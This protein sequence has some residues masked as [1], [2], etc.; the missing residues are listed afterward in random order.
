[1]DTEEHVVLS[2]SQKADVRRYRRLWISRQD[3]SEALAAIDLIDK[4]KLKRASRGA[5]PLDLVILTTAL[6]VSYS[7]PFVDTRG[8]K[9][10]AERTLPGSILRTLTRSQ[11]NLHNMLINMR[12]KEIAHSDAE[13]LELSFRI[14]PGGESAIW[15]TARDP[16]YRKELNSLRV[17]IGKIE[18][19]ID[20]ICN[21]LGIRLPNQTWL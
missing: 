10:L 21:D 15:R 16:L 12:Q 13:S 2:P 3:L 14:F 18:R 19:E 8:S 5:H 9:D 11:R 6:V 1:M 17:V 20:R 7:R 4:S